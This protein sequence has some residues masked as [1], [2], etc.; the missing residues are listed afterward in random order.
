MARRE[1]G[2]PPAYAFSK[3]AL[4]GAVLVIPAM[5]AAVFVLARFGIGDGAAP[6]SRALEAAVMFAGVPAILTAGGVGRL[7]ARAVIAPDKGTVGRGIGA[8]ALAFAAAGA[9]LV[10]LAAIPL[11]HL[12]EQPVRWLWVGA[13]GAVAG[14]MA[15]AVIGLWAGTGRVPQ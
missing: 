5:A 1:V 2:Q 15:G 13:A 3:G 10:L 7:A 8:A 4:L 9:G 12:P 14:A 6:F 11:G